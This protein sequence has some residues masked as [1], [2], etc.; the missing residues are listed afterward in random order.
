MIAKGVVVREP[1]AVARVEEI[2]LDPPA[3][4]EARVRILASGVCHTDL[5]AKHGHFGR[6]FPY[7]LGHEATGIVEEVG[8]S[9]N[10][11]LVGKTVMLSWRAP[12]RSCDF[13]SIGKLSH[14]RTPLTAGERM[15]TGDGKVLG[16]VLGLGTFATHTIVAVAQC[17]V[18]DDDLDPSATCLI[19]CGVVTGVGAVIFAAQVEAGH[20]VAVFGCGA[21]GLSVV[22]GARLARAGRIIAVDKEPR[23]LAWA[24]KF[25]ATDTIDVNEVDPVK[26]IKE[27]TGKRGVDHAFEAI[28]LPQTL[29]QAVASCGLGGSCTLIGVPQPKAEMSLALAP[30]FYGRLTVRATFYGDCLPDRDLKRM[31]DWY[32]RGELDLDAMVSERIR[33][34]AVE[35]AFA[36]MERGDTIRSVVTFD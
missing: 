3:R 8:E 6:S 11:P 7:L 27:L 28:G 22:Q 20:S 35:A 16:R 12:C 32:R 4:G 10:D 1:G 24:S 19:G 31:A 15:R 34:H 36:K 26:R 23:K 33:L 18:V 21:V 29:A 14:C 2:H 30:F 13:C 25:G 9:P 17:V 5:H